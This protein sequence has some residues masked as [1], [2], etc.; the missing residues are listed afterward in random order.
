M[1]A[2][3]AAGSG[4]APGVAQPP[5]KDLLLLAVGV[6]GASTAPP[7]VAATAAPALAIAFWRNAAGALAVL[8]FA[9]VRNRRELLRMPAR[10][11]G[12]GLLAGALL[13]AHFAAFMSSLRYTSVASAAALACSQIVWAALFSR[14]LGER[15]PGRAWAG[16]AL[17]LIGVLLVTGVDVSLAARALGG[18]LLALLSAVFGAPTWSSAARHAAR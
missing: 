3:A 4:R 10:S 13:A 2:P 15:L 12:L 9:L 17:S 11:F 18:D 8:P 1:S 6:L 14:L 16:T 5:A 7:L